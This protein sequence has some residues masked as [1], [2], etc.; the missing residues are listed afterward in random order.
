MHSFVPPFFLCLIAIFGVGEIQGKPLND[1]WLTIFSE[2]SQWNTNW[3]RARVLYDTR[4]GVFGFAHRASTYRRNPQSSQTRILFVD[5]DGFTWIYSPKTAS[6]TR[7]SASDIRDD[8]HSSFM[9]NFSQLLENSIPSL[10]GTRIIA[11]AGTR[12]AFRERK[13]SNETWLFNGASERWT[14]LTFTSEVPPAR[15]GHVAFSYYRNE[16]P[17]QC[18]ESV[19]VFGGKDANN[20]VLYDFWELQCVDDRNETNMNYE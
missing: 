4:E 17:C 14:A 9:K 2:A 20:E 19:I 18:K 6:R 5:F 1:N 15:F 12:N 8:E 13:A 16:S 3:P 10:C 11:F 7:L